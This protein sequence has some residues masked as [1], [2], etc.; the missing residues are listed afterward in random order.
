MMGPL[1]YLTQMTD[2]RVRFRVPPRR[3]KGIRRHAVNAL[4]S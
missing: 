1:S 4:V 2:A 3:F